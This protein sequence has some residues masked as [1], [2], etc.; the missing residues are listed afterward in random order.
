MNGIAPHVSTRDVGVVDL[1]ANTFTKTDEHADMNNDSSST[2]PSPSSL[3]C[4]L[5]RQV[6]YSALFLRIPREGTHLP[7]HLS[8]RGL[9][10][11]S[12][13]QHMPT[14]CSSAVRMDREVDSVELAL[15][16]PTNSGELKLTA[17][18]VLHHLCH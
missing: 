15:M 6:V 14:G 17:L 16:L 12:R 9:L 13:S 7:C 4:L 3:W 1:V 10:F 11:L 8:T 2:A 5:I 18:G